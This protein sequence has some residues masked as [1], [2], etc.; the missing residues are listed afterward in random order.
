MTEEKNP[1]KSK[2]DGKQTIDLDRQTKGTMSEINETLSDLK[3]LLKVVTYLGIKTEDERGREAITSAMKN[4]KTGDLEKTKDSLE[5]SC[6]FLKQKID[7][8]VEKELKKMESQANL[9]EDETR[10]RDIERAIS[11]LEKAKED[12]DYDDLPDLFFQ[13]WDEVKKR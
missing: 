5:K 12:K 13:A 3:H 11:K 4:V 7:K 6:E 8:T 1:E 2:R 10:D 9:K